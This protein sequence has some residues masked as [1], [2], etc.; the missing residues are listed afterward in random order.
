MTT[1]FTKFDGTPVKFF[2]YVTDV[3]LL[4]A[5]KE[6]SWL[7]DR[8]SDPYP[9]Y[10]RR[11]Y[12]RKHRNED[13]HHDRRTIKEYKEKLWKVDQQIE[14]A[15]AFFRRTLTSDID[16]SLNQFWIKENFNIRYQIYEA[17][18]FMKNK[19]GAM[20]S[21]AI[22]QLENQ[23][24]LGPIVYTYPEAIEFVKKLISINTQLASFPKTTEKTYVR[25]AESWLSY[26]VKHGRSL[27]K[28]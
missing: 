4:M 5:E 26:L 14:S 15:I 28:N 24:L 2:R 8:D 22:L 21:A 16:D 20:T 13:D 10:P 1:S 17:W 9:D 11:E 12:A 18:T 7:L 23:M 19:Y 25:R 6:C 3:Q 27:T